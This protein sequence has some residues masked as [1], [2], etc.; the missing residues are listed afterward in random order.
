MSAIL[1]AKRAVERRLIQAFPTTAISLENVEFNPTDNLYLR[2]AFRVNNPT[3]DSIGNDCYRENITFTV[4][5]CDK[6]NKGTGNAINV[7]EQVRSTFYKRLTLQENTTRV[8][9][10]Q[11][12]QVGT[13]VKTVDRL[14]VPVVISLTVEVN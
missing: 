9:V 12:P 11:V 8:H 5:V 13:A 7:A 10:L 3:D 14:V 4:F 6:L 1:D 2:T